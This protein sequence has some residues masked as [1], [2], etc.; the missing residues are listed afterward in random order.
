MVSDSVYEELN[1]AVIGVGRDVARASLLQ[2]GYPA[3]VLVE[4]AISVRS[5]FLMSCS[6]YTRAYTHTTKRRCGRP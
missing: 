4:E 1:F 2:R 5:R 6:A 3:E